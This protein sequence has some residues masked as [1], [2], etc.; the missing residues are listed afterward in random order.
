VGSGEFYIT[1]T[2]LDGENALRVT[3]MNP[4]TGKGELASLLNALRENAKALG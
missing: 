2:Q 1:A 4:L 3:I